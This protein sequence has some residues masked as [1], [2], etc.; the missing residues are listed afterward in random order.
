M[1]AK[2]Y[3]ERDCY[4]C[5]RGHIYRPPTIHGGLGQWVP[6]PTC[7]GTARAMTYIYPR[8]GRR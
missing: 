1:E 8:R 7:N 2:T 3:E 4:R 6:C 5:H